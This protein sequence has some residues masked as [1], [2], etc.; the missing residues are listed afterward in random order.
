MTV[1][2]GG[3]IPTVGGGMGERGGGVSVAA[4]AMG[5]AEG[6][7]LVLV[8]GA[9]LGGGRGGAFGGGLSEMEKITG[10]YSLPMA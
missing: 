4:E 3:N 2:R 8:A 5:A 9:K 1:A 7:W 6:G 10:R